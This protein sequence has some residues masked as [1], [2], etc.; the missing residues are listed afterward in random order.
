M[1]IEET[2]KTKEKEETADKVISLLKDVNLPKGFKVEAE[3]SSA[4]LKFHSFFGWE[5]NVAVI[6]LAEDNIIEVV[7]EKEGKYELLKDCFENSKTK[8]RVIMGS[9]YY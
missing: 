7:F 8:F 2:D 5:E 4:T 3:N 9:W 1:I 6:S